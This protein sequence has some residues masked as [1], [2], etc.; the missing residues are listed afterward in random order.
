MKSKTVLLALLLAAASTA[1]AQAP[2][3]SA[4]ASAAASSPAKK[5][6]VQRLLTL[7]QGSIEAISRSVV[8]RPV[9]Q[10]MQRAAQLLQT[11]VAAEK[12]EATAKSMEADI[13]QFVNDAVPLLRDR[14]LKIAP[15]TYGSMLEDRFTEDEL[16]QFVTWLES[17]ASKKF[18]QLGPDMQTAFAQNLG[19][20]ANTLLTARLKALE[21]KLSATLG[22]PSLAAEG[23]RP[24][25]S[26]PK[27]AK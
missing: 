16:R 2:A 10:L 4:P 21:Q 22:V 26:K 15:A 3:P 23:A 6:L 14:A 20:E 27:A 9:A 5:E 18:Q 24:A 1:R 19:T 17:P 12:R 13:R 25:A 11:R 8:E 7:Q